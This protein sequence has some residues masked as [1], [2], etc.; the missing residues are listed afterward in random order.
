MAKAQT[1]ADK[2]AK[3]KSQKSAVCPECGEVF[4]YMKVV[5]PVA[6]ASGSY[7]FQRKMEKHCKCK[8]T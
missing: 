6:S 1:F 3:A 8:N 5:E 4:I 2:V 7:R